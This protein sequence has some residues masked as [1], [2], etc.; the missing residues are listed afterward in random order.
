MICKSM[1]RLKYGASIGRMVW[2]RERLIVLELSMRLRSQVGCR[3][4]PPQQFIGYCSGSASFHAL[5]S[6]LHRPGIYM[7]GLCPLLVLSKHSS[8]QSF[9]MSMTMAS[10]A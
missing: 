10:R 2:S 3:N 9:A 7:C 5:D 4:Q 6:P 1:N 8:M